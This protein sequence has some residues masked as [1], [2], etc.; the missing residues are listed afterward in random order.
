MSLSK[1]KK[2]F[3]FI[4][5][6]LNISLQS[7]CNSTPLLCFP[8]EQ[9]Q[10]SKTHEPDHQKLRLISDG[11]GVTSNKT[12]ALCLT[13]LKADDCKAPEQEAVTI[14]LPDVQEQVSR[15]PTPGAEQKQS[16]TRLTP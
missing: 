3:H 16:L 6:S 11:K 8:R 14:T 13:D 9:Q 7:I 1:K 10:C 4:T 15:S 12:R 2:T 5:L